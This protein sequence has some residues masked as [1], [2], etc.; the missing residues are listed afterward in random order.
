[1]CDCDE[2]N[3]WEWI[4]TRVLCV[5]AN[6][7]RAVMGCLLLMAMTAIQY[8]MRWTVKT[9]V[10]WLDFIFLFLLG[11]FRYPK[12]KSNG[13]FFGVVAMRRNRI[14]GNMVINAKNKTSMSPTQHYAHC[15]S[16]NW[17]HFSHLISSND[18]FTEFKWLLYNIIHSLMVN[19]HRQICKFN[20]NFLSRRLLWTKINKNAF[21]SLIV[22]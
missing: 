15:T 4:T 12:N 16:N 6:S 2:R 9:W 1:M 3:E 18:D 13:F 20:C 19:W 7:I 8:E 14:Y 17:P 10:N 11:K 21:A 22:A 5:C